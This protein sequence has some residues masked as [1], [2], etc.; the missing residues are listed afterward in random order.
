M[1]QSTSPLTN[2][3]LGNRIADLRKKAGITQEQLADHLGLTYQAVSKWENGLSCPDI[4]LLPKLAAIFGVSVDSLLGNPAD[5]SIPGKIADPDLGL[6]WP[7][8]QTLRMVVFRGR[9]LLN[10]SDHNA[11]GLTFTLEGP[12]LDVVCEGSLS[13]GD[14][15]GDA[16]AGG[17]IS[18][19]DIDG[20]VKADGGVNCGDVGGGIKAGGGVCCG[21]VEGD[22]KTENS[23][24][25][26]DIGGSCVAGNNI[27]CGDIE[28]NASAGT[29]IVCGDIGGNAVA[30][31]IKKSI[32]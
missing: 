8:D 5:N 21:D 6:D 15:D 9:Q 32:D 2:E 1:N 24:E 19:G 11:T 25:C 23:V 3:A 4:L 22:I 14:I 10:H 18:C 26:G 28:G 13:C 16:K 30:N 12:A 29:S 20:D 7:D 31:S 17:S 27:T